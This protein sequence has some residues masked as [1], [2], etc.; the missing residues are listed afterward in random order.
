VASN[1]EPGSGRGNL[2][3]IN[4]VLAVVDALL[5]AAVIFLFIR[6]GGGLPF[7]GAR[8]DGDEAPAERQMQPAEGERDTSDAEE[9]APEVEPEQEDTQAAAREE[10]GAA[11][12]APVSP[13]AR[14]V[15]ARHTVESGDTF[16]DIAGRYWENEHLWPDLYV[17]NAEK[18]SDPD[19]VRPGEV[20]AIYPSLAADGELS[21]SDVEVISEAYVR[22]YRTYRRLGTAALEQAGAE[23]S[24]YWVA[25]ARNKINK[26]HWLLYS[27]HRFNRN[28]T[29][30]YADRIDER[31]LAVVER[32]LK[33]FGYPPDP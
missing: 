25:R 6:P 27:G 17:L 1:A 9:P 14:E 20:V 28:L 4:I 30:D 15:R 23:H 2:V 19:L 13:G 7:A 31:D 29:A 16:Y 8:A 11:G 18:F 21:R 32:Y 22:T 3:R 24:R 26:A 5:L 10:D 12:E 33:R